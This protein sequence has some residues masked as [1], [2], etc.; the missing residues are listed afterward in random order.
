MI[1][2]RKWKEVISVFKFPNSVTSA[3]FVLRKYYQSLLYDFEQVYYFRKKSP[4]FLMP[5]KKQLLFVLLTDDV[6]DFVLKHQNM[7]FK[8]AKKE[9]A[10][11]TD[12]LFHIIR[13]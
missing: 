7:Q 1:G 9:F 4:S 13:F 2:D 10:L 6:I 3:S 5:G 8:L 12:Q 11:L